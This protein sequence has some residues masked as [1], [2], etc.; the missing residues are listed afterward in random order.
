[1]TFPSTIGLLLAGLGAALSVGVFLRERA[2]S[3]SFDIW[4]FSDDPAFCACA[5][6]IENGP[7]TQLTTD[8]CT[9]NPPF[10]YVT[11]PS[12]SPGT[13]TQTKH[14]CVDSDGACSATVRAELRFPAGTC[15]GTGGVVG[16]GI[17]TMS[18]PCQAIASGP[19]APATVTWTLSAKCKTD[20]AGTS[21]PA[22]G[23]G[24]AS[25]IRFW[26]AGCGA[27]GSVP[28]ANPNLI[29]NPKLKCGA[30]Q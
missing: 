11:T 6:T 27:G 15:A 5:P 19:G 17:G 3:T 29:F 2:E 24:S 18:S 26:C 9:P 7:G 10:L 23:G 14:G 13:C 28:A 21:D 30:C 8:C 20:P 12:I 16:P 1:M 4:V 25:P 22:Q